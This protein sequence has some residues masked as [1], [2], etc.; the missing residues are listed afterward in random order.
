MRHTLASLVLALFL[1]PSIA[2]GETVKYEDLVKREGVYFEKHTDVPFTGKITGKKRGHSRTVREMVLG[3]VITT[4]DSCKRKKPTRTENY[5]VL[6]SGITRT[7][8]WGGKEPTRTGNSTVLRR[9][10]TRTVS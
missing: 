6:M 5:T 7:V 10:I 1:F 8:S 2:M 3:S 4:T 9:S